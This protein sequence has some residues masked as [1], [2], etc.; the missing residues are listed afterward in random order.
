MRRTGSDNLIQA[1]PAVPG[2]VPAART[3]IA[4][5]AR[6]AGAS[7]E[8][9]DDIRLA[10]SEALTNVV[11]HAYRDRGRG[12]I[13]VRAALAAGELWLLIGDDGSGLRTGTGSSGLGVGLALICEITHGFAVVNRSSGG[14]EVR[15][16]F[17]L[18]T[19]RIETGE[20]QSVVARASVSAPASS[21]FST[22]T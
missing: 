12:R 17:S 1:Y 5:L 11:L 2:S 7:D 3:A 8:Q 20:P 18:S 6:R 13:H 4:D 19:A 14:T 22:T 9:L 21:S 16:R 15:V 10:A